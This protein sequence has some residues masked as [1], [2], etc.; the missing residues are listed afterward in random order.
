VET[1]CRG[2]TVAF[3]NSILQIHA[4]VSHDFTMRRFQ[5]EVLMC[6]YT[7]FCIF[8]ILDDRNVMKRVN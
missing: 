5:Q 3:E 7:N 6:K 4:N 8:H 2:I 1:V